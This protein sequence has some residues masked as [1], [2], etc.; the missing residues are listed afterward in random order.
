[1]QL[2]KNRQN[3][4]QQRIQVDLNEL[5]LLLVTLNDSAM[6][7]IL[8]YRIRTALRV[9]EFYMVYWRTQNDVTLRYDTTEGLTWLA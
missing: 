7:C 4:L 6:Q 1:M 9:T 5:G 2:I 8:L 3:D